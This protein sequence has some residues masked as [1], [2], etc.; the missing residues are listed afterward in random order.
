MRK[1]KIL[2][3]IM[4]LSLLLSGCGSTES[5]SNTTEPDETSETVE[6]TVS[7]VEEATPTPAQLSD[8]EI[9]LMQGHPKYLGVLEKAHEIWDGLGLEPD[10]I[11]FGDDSF[12]D[13]SANTILNLW[14][15]YNDYSVI[16]K[17]S[18]LFYNSDMN[19][20]SMD[21]AIEIAHDYLPYDSSFKIKK[22]KGEKY[23][24]DEGTDYYIYYN[25]SDGDVFQVLFY[26]EGGD[27]KIDS[28]EIGL[29]KRNYRTSDKYDYK[30]WKVPKLMKEQ[31]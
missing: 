1:K 27:K 29:V 20:V 6:E 25:S 21:E 30:K 18:I 8:K 16:R 14:C 15:N 12:T 10:K 22:I 9:L 7:P 31:P 2:V 4:I 17:V 11:K 19:A 5:S 3:S 28:V 24:G 26:D 13:A 23:F